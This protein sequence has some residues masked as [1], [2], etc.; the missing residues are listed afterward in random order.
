MELIK[1][2]GIK[3]VYYSN[4]TTLVCQKTEDIVNDHVSSRYSKPWK[5]WNKENAIRE[6]QIRDNLKI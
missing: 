3:K 5:E 6:N 1:K 4:G 2:Y